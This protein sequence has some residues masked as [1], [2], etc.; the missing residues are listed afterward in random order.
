M[1]TIV[2]SGLYIFYFCFH[3]SF[4]RKK[5]LSLAAKLGYIDELSQPCHCSDYY[6][7]MIHQY[8]KIKVTQQNPSFPSILQEQR[9]KPITLWPE[10]MKIKFLVS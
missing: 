10:K 9:K 2:E 7:Q 4:I 8:T 1:N 3:I 6:F 5:S